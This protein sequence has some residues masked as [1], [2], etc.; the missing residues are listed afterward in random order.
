MGKKK[1]AVSKS[2]LI[3]EYLADHADAQNKDVAVALQKHGVKS[4][5]VANLKTRMK[6][7]GTRKK[8]KK[9]STKTQPRRKPATSTVGLPAVEAAADLIAAVGGVDAAQ[10]AL[11]AATKIA[12]KLR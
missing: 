3:R 2:Q 11:S 9:K 7:K 1:A 6:T 12:K 10:Q 5:D 8:K 4:Q